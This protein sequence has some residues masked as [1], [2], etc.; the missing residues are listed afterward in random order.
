M[1]D[2]AALIFS[3][4]VIFQLVTL[5][6]ILIAWFIAYRWLQEYERQEDV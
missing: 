6:V 2:S 3:Y 5:V 1:R 4:P